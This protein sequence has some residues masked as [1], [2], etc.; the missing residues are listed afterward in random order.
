MK[1]LQPSND[2]RKHNGL[3]RI[4]A[5]DKFSSWREADYL[6]VQ[7]SRIDYES[8]VAKWIHPVFHVL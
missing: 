7:V 2:G 5:A 1:I 4:S 3:A 8:I 6:G